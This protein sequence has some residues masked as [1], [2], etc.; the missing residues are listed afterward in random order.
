MHKKA[1]EIKERI[2]GSE[3]CLT[4]SWCDRYCSHSLSSRLTKVERFSQNISV[5]FATSSQI[6][7]ELLFFLRLRNTMLK[8]YGPIKCLYLTG[9]SR[10]G[11][12]NECPPGLLETKYMAYFFQGGVERSAIC[13]YMLL[14]IRFT[15]EW[16]IFASYFPQYP[17]YCG[18]VNVFVVILFNL[19][20][21]LWSSIV[22]GSFGVIVQLRHGTIR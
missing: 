10:L 8:R 11:Q 9:R 13:Q 12:I 20:I 15:A 6:L 17:I 5:K 18:E 14:V 19:V 3:V 4:G 16:K 1:I 7:V 22:I 21:G 2:L